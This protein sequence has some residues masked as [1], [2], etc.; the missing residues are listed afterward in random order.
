MRQILGAILLGGLVL[1]ARAGA[2]PAITG[3]IDPMAFSRLKDFTAHRSSS[4]SPLPDWND[5]SKHPLPAETLTRGSIGKASVP[6]LEA[7]RS[8]LTNPSA[9]WV[10][11]RVIQD[12]EGAQK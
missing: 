6:A 4:N 1:S 3:P 2:Q 12:I 11:Q 5:D 9:G 7:I 10:A 8:T